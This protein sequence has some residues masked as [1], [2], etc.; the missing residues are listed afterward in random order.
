[1]HK[2]K[3]RFKSRLPRKQKKREGIARKKW[4][5][6]FMRSNEERLRPWYGDD[7]LSHIIIGG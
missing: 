1:M 3:E 5:E 7:W 4:V 6:E 2:G